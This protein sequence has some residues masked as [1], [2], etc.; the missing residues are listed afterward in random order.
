MDRPRDARTARASTV[1]DYDFVSELAAT[2]RA[3]AHEPRKRH[4]ARA[5][6]VVVER[7][8]LLSVAL[9]DVER[10]VLGKVFPL[11]H[12]TRPSGSQRG[13]DLVHEGVILR[14][15]HSLLGP[16]EVFGSGE[17]FCPVRADVQDHRLRA[18]WAHAARGVEGELADGDGKPAPAL[19]ADAENRRRIGGDDDPHVVERTALRG[20]P[21]P[22]D[23]E[24]RERQTPRPAI[25]LRRVG[26]GLTD[27]GRV[28]DGQ[29]LAQVPLEKRVE[30]DLVSLLQT[31][32]V[33]VLGE[34]GRLLQESG[35]R[36]LDLAVQRRHTRRKQPFEAQRDA[37]A[38][39][40]GGALVEEGEAQKSRA[41]D[42]DAQALPP[43]GVS[44]KLEIT[45]EAR[46]DRERFAPR[47][48]VSNLVRN[49][50]PG[51]DS[52]A[53][54]RPSFTDRGTL[55]V[56]EPPRIVWESPGACAASAHSEDLLRQA[57]ASARAPGLAWGVRIRV[58]PTSDHTL[59]AEGQIMGEGGTVV[60]RRLLSGAP[61][62]CDGLAR[63]VGVWA[64][65]VLDAQ[66]ARADSAES[67]TT[68]SSPAG[69]AASDGSSGA[70][71]STAMEVAL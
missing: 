53:W 35:V 9:E 47:R 62:D 18:I 38:L 24:R 12:G 63:A 50:G 5:L 15:P 3:R 25:D 58:E 64:S 41:V 42:P 66:R 28:D 56:T 23:I 1:D 13:H 6:D 48:G 11:D 31:T 55:D 20:L 59:R 69:S 49:V 30:E 21:R 22:V 19:I 33:R 37:L 7:G 26:D 71:G 27:G 65:L 54:L 46:H 52:P 17:Q 45:G 70:T 57:V 40:E 4:G 67:A 51:I 10:R 16:A 36:P 61:G 34:G 32:Q 8:D 68:R 29:H 60:A 14:P 43:I 2:E 39:R 44:D